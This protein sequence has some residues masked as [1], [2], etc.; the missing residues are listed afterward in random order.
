MQLK[1]SKFLD[2]FRHDITQCL[3][4]IG[5]YMDIAK[6]RMTF[7]VYQNLSALVT[8]PRRCWTVIE[9]K[10]PSRILETIF[11]VQQSVNS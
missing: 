7:Y 1:G 11:Y 8:M 10:I 9:L 2:E 5:M 3:S 4:S 6:G